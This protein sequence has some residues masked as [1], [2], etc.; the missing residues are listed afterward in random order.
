[1][2]FRFVPFV[3]LAGFGIVVG[4]GCNTTATEM[5]K[6]D[7]DCKGS[8]VCKEGLCEDPGTTTGDG[9]TSMS[10]SGGTSASSIPGKVCNKPEDC[11]GLPGSYCSKAGVCARTCTLHTDCGCADG[12]TN[13]DLANGKCGAACVN[14]G[15]DTGGICLKVCANSGQ[16]LGATTCKMPSSTSGFSACM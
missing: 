7:G 1:M 15:G 8:R 14:F 13:T 2:K 9:G 11:A 3:A 5:C 6:S 12:T 16:C 4:L 10:D